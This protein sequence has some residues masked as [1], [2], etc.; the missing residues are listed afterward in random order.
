MP[1]GTNAGEGGCGGFPLSCKGGQEMS[2]RSFWI[3]K[4]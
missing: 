1:S 3:T 4:I 2:V